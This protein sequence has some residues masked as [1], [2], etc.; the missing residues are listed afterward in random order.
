MGLYERL[1]LLKANVMLCAYRK[2]KDHL[3]T[4]LVKKL[5]HPSFDV[6]EY[7][8]S[9]GASGG[10]III[11]KSSLFQGHLSFQNNFAISVEFKAKYN[12][13]KCVLTNVYGPCTS[14]G[15][16]EFTSWLKSIQMPDDTDWLLLGDFNLMRS[17]DD[18]NKPGGNVSEMS[19]FNEAISAL[20]LVELPL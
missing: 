6:F 9:L 18:R 19:L 13:M 1:N 10:I 11:W 3:L 4:L 20:R 15:K 16:I 14:E 2:P 8:L 7:L 12:Y 17:P 5:C